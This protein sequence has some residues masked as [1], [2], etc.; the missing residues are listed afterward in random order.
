VCSI[1]R[2]RQWFGPNL[3]RR[4]CHD[5]SHYPW[6]AAGLCGACRHAGV[7]AVAVSLQD[8]VATITPALEGGAGL[9]GAWALLGT[10]GSSVGIVECPYRHAFASPQERA[11][12]QKLRARNER[13]V[14]LLTSDWSLRVATRSNCILRCAWYSPADESYAHLNQTGRRASRK[15]NWQTCRPFGLSRRS[16]G[17]PG[18]CRASTRR[19]L[20]PRT[21]GRRFSRASL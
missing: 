17:R 10:C 8:A 20:R 4:P 13:C 11:T 9:C 14:R 12:A 2:Q 18:A 7:T 15:S 19:S 5:C 16:C 21:A 1:A 3:N 6:R